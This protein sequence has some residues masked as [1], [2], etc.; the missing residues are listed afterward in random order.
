MSAEAHGYIDDARWFAGWLIRLN[1]TN[2]ATENIAAFVALR[3]VR[4]MAAP[5]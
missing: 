4:V 1:A 2:T 5:V 3:N